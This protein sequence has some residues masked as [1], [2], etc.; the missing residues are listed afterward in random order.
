[1]CLE[2]MLLGLAENLE[3]LEN[4]KSVKCCWFWRYS[5]DLY[6]I[7]LIIYVVIECY[8]TVIAYNASTQY[9]EM[10]CDLS[11]TWAPLHPF[12]LSFHFGKPSAKMN[13]WQ[14]ESTVPGFWVWQSVLVQLR[15][16][17]RGRDSW[18]TNLFNVPSVLATSAA[19]T[20]PFQSIPI[21]LTLWFWTCLNIV[22]MYVH[23]LHKRDPAATSALQT[24]K[25]QKCRVEAYLD[26][27]NEQNPEV[28]RCFPARTQQPSGKWWRD[29]CDVAMHSLYYIVLHSCA[30]WEWCA[31]NVVT[32]WCLGTPYL[33]SMSY[34]ARVQVD[35]GWSQTAG[36]PQARWS[37]CTWFTHKLM[38]V[39]IND[40]E[41][42]WM[43]N[44]IMIL[45]DSGCSGCNMVQL[46][47][48]PQLA[49][50]FCNS[51]CGLYR[52]HCSEV[53]TL[54]FPVALVANLWTH[55]SPAN[56]LCLALKTSKNRPRFREL[57]CYITYIILYR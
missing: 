18:K 10:M 48:T 12:P 8:W 30:F 41:C 51:T 53:G 16:V 26:E 33:A 24:W 17:M 31:S 49:M 43:W 5:G 14:S 50:G 28:T 29:R 40:I 27:C 52:P 25:W 34:F 45:E 56:N 20:T 35:S 38:V 6:T 7:F 42:G 39:N 22:C 47:F 19:I 44:A 13:G 57:I 54:I 4:S 55:L 1:M 3:N 32:T 23:G 9:T 37:R 15:N 36:R 2:S 46:R 11:F 21:S